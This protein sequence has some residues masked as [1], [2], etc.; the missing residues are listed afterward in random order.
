MKNRR[1][2]NVEKTSAIDI[3][4]YTLRGNNNDD[5]GDSDHEEANQGRE[6]EGEGAPIETKSKPNINELTT[7][8]R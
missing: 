1:R 3:A 7:K 8:K 5:E 6:E 4:Q 2:V